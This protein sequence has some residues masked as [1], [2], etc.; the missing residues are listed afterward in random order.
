MD[1]RRLGLRQVRASHSDTSVVVYQAYSAAIALPAVQSQRFVAP[2]RLQRTTWIKPSFLWMMYR[3]GWAQKSG[4]EHILRITLR[5]DAFD[6]FLEQA[7][8]SHYVPEVHPSEAQWKKQV[9]AAPVVVQW[10]P[11]R[12]AALQPLSGRTIQLGLRGSAV[13]RY[14]AEA[15][16]SIEEATSMARRARNDLA[17]KKDDLLHDILAAERIYPVPANAARQLGVTV[18]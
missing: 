3:S 9:H 14:V 1:T 2:F 15:I 18:D 13:Q 4:Q 5:R 11:E 17:Q 6:W 12:N 7:V 16:V 8:L 10:D